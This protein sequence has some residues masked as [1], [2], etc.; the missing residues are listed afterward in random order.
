MATLIAMMTFP[1]KHTHACIHTCI[2]NIHIMCCFNAE[3]LLDLGFRWDKP[4]VSKPAWLQSRGT[5]A[6]DRAE[7]PPS[8]QEL[9]QNLPKA[10]EWKAKL[11]TPYRTRAAGGR[12]HICKGWGKAAFTSTS[13][14]CQLRFQTARA[15]LSTLLFCR[16]GFTFP[17]TATP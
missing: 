13:R 5:P 10:G 7:H 6:K 4:T 12:Q 1:A 3:T 8:L 15:S 14:L 9:Q 11:C 2:I 17:V 16:T